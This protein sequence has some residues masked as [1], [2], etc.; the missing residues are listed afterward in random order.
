MRREVRIMTEQATAPEEEHEPTDIEL[1]RTLANP[2]RLAIV[3][4]LG[5]TGGTATATELGELVGLSPSATSYHLRALA[6]AGVI[7]PAEGRGDGR[8]RPWR[9]I[10]AGRQIETELSGEPE[11]AAAERA[12]LGV[13]LARADERVTAWLAHEADAPD[14][15][16]RAMSIFDTQL[17]V[18][19]DELME[20]NAAYQELLRPYQRRDRPAPPIGARAV[21]AHYRVVPS[22]S[23]HEPASSPM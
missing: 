14:D 21:T 22:T 18:T 2:T 19:P 13:V 3:E 11:R 16:A 12:L 9:A 17:I 10:G 6:K 1:I 8:E 5:S 7:E 4:Y 15:W 20:I 23:P